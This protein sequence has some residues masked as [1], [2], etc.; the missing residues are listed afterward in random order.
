MFKKH[1]LKYKAWFTVQRPAF[2]YGI[3]LGGLLILWMVSGALQPS[4]P[5][6]AD[7]TQ[8]PL[9]Q[10]KQST[11]ETITRILTL[12]GQI[13]PDK[14][15]TLRAETE[16]V[17]EDRLIKEGQPIDEGTVLIRLATDDRE[18]RLRQ[19]KASVKQYNLEYES[20]KKL[21]EQGFQAKNRVAGSLAALEEAKAKLSATQKEINNSIIRAPFDGV[22]QE[23]YLEKGDTV[24]V[25]TQVARVISIDPLVL[26]GHI[27]QSEIENINPQ[28]KAWGVL[29]NGS[30]LEGDV[31]YISAEAHAQTRT[32]RVEVATPNPQHRRLAGS[33]VT[34]KIPLSD[35]TAHFISP[36]FL[37]LSAQGV[38]G[39]KVLGDG[40][41]AV[42]APVQLEQTTP[43]GVWVSGLPKSVTLITLG[44][45]F[46][47]DGDKVRTAE[48]V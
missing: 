11:G 46:V 5:K 35:V 14:A 44:H 25:G 24:T 19:A 26:E 2:R 23:I 29:P 21:G 7:T 34:I 6:Q 22:L 27:P 15:V 17:V 20:A 13:M 28:G 48:G 38:L 32:Y 43:D 47:K 45:G 4:A 39:V 37:S 31:R 41:K 30:E 33:S 16:G 18:A 8:P 9:V 42:F 3:I 40:H 10:T 12:E 1:L 36:A